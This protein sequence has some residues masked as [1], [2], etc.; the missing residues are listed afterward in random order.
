MRD[1]RKARRGPD[2]RRRRIYR[3]FMNLRRM[4]V[5]RRIAIEA[6]YIMEGGR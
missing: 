6:S 3:A 2:R 4:G 1:R 5:G